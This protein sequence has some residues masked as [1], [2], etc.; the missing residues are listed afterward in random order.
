MKNKI[1]KGFSSRLL[2]FLA[3]FTAFLV[4]AKSIENPVIYYSFFVVMSIFGYIFIFRPVI[5]IEKMVSSAVNGDYSIKK[6]ILG[7]AGRLGEELNLLFNRQMVSQESLNILFAASK[8]ITSRI[9]ID[10]VVNMLLDL[11]HQ[12]MMMPSTSIVFLDDDGFLRIKASRGLTDEFVK[13]IHLRPGEGF[14]GRAFL[15]KETLI[16]N[17]ATKE[18]SPETEKQVE[19]EGLMSFVHIPIIVN[20]KAIGVFNVNSKTKRFFDTN[21]VRTLSTLAD[22]LAVAVGNSKMYQ[23]MQEFNRRLELEVESTTEELTNTNL[24][25][26]SKVKEMKSLNDII[27]SA[28]GKINIDEMFATVIDKI[29]F[30][31]GVSIAGFMIYDEQNDT[32]VGVGDFKGFELSLKDETPAIL[33]KLFK[34]VSTFISNELFMESSPDI[35]RLYKDY[36]ATSIIALPLVE[37]KTIGLL[38]LGNKVTGKFSHDDLRFLSVVAS[39][40]AGLIDRAKVYEQLSRRVNDLIIL[41]DISNTIKTE[42]QLDEIIEVLADKTIR[43]LE[44]DYAIFWLV[45]DSGENLTPLFPPDYAKKDIMKIPVKS[46]ALITKIFAEGKIQTTNAMEFQNEA[47]NKLRETSGVKSHL[48]VPLKV[49]EK[50]IGLFCFCSKTQNFFND[51]K[52]R[53]AELMAGQTAAI[54]ENARIHNHLKKVNAELERLNSVKNDF[55]SIVSHELRTPLTAIKGF[56]HVVLSEEAGKINEQQKNFLG[57]VDQSS[58]HLNRLISDLLDLSKIESGLITLKP[59]Q[60]DLADVVKKSA[61]TNINQIKNKDIE[62]QLEID[63]ELPKISG[64]HSRLMQVYN[65]LISNAVKFTDIRG[66][67]TITVKEKG[68]FIISSISDNGIGIPKEEHKKI[69]D[70]FYQVD[71]SHTRIARGTGLGLF[72]VKTIVELH[73]G[74]IWLDSTPGSGSTFSFLLPKIKKAGGVRKAGRE[75]ER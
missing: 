46:E 4:F 31:T 50:N 72:I 59:E 23:E 66:Q 10:D 51:D 42:P 14:A 39:Q 6:D 2:F 43:A 35:Q 44:S 71:S 34:N 45:D 64:D 28:T 21:L 12:K 36:G 60:L 38:I 55:V 47:Y 41:R 5:F 54:V 70:K 68:D 8:T 13:N 3:I 74:N 17:D 7:K 48:F 52:I 73:G 18:K 24:R 67:I 37:K 9:E 20:D 26:I 57:I 53:L 16:I 75:V 63:K 30:V 11:V 22:Y 62:L 25:L 27:F 1:A 29:K 65:N 49:E 15:T 56:V 69:F 40:I 19:S 58:D 61:E 32:L 33:I